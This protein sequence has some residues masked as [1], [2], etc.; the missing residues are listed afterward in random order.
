MAYSMLAPASPQEDQTLQTPEKAQGP[1]GKAASV[2]DRTQ[3]TL[4]FLPVPVNTG[5]CPVTQ[6]NQAWEE[7]PQNSRQSSLFSS[8]NSLDVLNN[9]LSNSLGIF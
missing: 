1:R 6:Q 9:Y 4:K 8:T 5:T 3:N 2:T 7:M